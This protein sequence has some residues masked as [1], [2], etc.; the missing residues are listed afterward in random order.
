MWDMNTVLNLQIRSTDSDVT[1]TLGAN[2]GSHLKGG[3]VI[4]L[5]S[6]L[7]GG[8]TT[9]TRGL[10]RGAGSEDH[11]SSPTFTVS[12]IYQANDL[13][14]HHFDLY[15][16]QEAGIMAHEIVELQQDPENVLV[17]EW[18]GVADNVL[19]EQRLIVSFEA[20]SELQRDITLT[21][22]EQ[23]SYLVKDLQ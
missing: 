2:I 5:T 3:E 10:V 8:K 22:P 11:V 18:A 9:F 6:D 23:L 12:K 16:L 1:E 13:Q 17:L 4:E 19:P 14:I 7:G 20:L 15:R 21:Y